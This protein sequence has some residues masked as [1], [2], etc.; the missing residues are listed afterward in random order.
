M[1]VAKCPSCGA[2][3][4]F[5]DP[6]R[7]WICTG[8]KCLTA[9][10]E[11][12]DPAVVRIPA[13][14]GS[15][16]SFMASDGPKGIL[17]LGES[18]LDSDPSS[19]MGWYCIGRSAMAQGLLL[20]GS[21]CWRHAV[22]YMDRSLPDPDGLASHMAEIM[23]SSFRTSMRTGRKGGAFAVAG[24]QE[25]MIRKF[26]RIGYDMPA[27]I[28]HG[29]TEGLE[30]MPDRDRFRPSSSPPP[31]GST[32]SNSSRTSAACSLCSGQSWRRRPA[33]P[34]RWVGSAS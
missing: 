32:A 11:P 26:G 23:V 14:V 7:Y 12:S 27:R 2:D 10:R 15:V 20:E 17:S 21:L 19:W 28:Y 13:D 34:T 33:Y 5:P 3:C 9:H 18:L 29:L 31:N 16:E 1:S 24:I 22:G 30:D 6:P 8:S 4:P 25:A